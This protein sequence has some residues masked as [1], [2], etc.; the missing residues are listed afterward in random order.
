[1]VCIHSAEVSLSPVVGLQQKVPVLPA[2]SLCCPDQF[3]QHLVQQA[4]PLQRSQATHKLCCL[5]PALPFLMI[6]Y[7]LFSTCLC[8]AQG[9]VVTSNQQG[10]SKP[11][12]ATEWDAVSKINKQTNKQTKKLRPQIKSQDFRA[13]SKSQV[14][15][16][17]FLLL[18][19]S[20]FS[21][22]A[23]LEF[24]L[25]TWALIQHPVVGI[26]GSLAHHFWVSTLQSKLNEDTPF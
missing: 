2:S 11:G 20:H 3:L 25:Q 21:T 18:S 7:L 1:M 4:T 16:V 17:D 14:W 19:L 10:D 24:E 8:N 22:P 26:P 15:K 12:W 13:G 5:I 23:C 9:S 6:S